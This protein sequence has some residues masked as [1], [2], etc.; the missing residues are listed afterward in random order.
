[1]SQYLRSITTRSLTAEMIRKLNEELMSDRSL[2]SQN[3]VK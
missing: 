3:I 2:K 1:M